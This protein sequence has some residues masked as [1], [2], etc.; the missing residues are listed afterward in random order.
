MNSN[1]IR[2]VNNPV[3]YILAIGILYSCQ[4][5]ERYYSS[6]D[7]DKVPKIDAHFHY[8][9]MDPTFIEYS[10]SLNFKLITPIWEGEESM[11]TPGPTAPESGCLH[12]AGQHTA[13]LQ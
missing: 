6:S 4:A 13:M 7:F 10:K 2:M 1:V 11:A 3:V 8:L 5:K 12:P 9:T